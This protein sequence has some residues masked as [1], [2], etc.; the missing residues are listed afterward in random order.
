MERSRIKKY[1]KLLGVNVL[2][3][4]VWTIL[5]SPGFVGL[6]LGESAL[7]SA[8]CISVGVTS[9]LGWLLYNVYSLSGRNVRML[10]SHESSLAELR[11]QLTQL[12]YKESVAG[13]V[14]SAVEQIDEWCTAREGYLKQVRIKFGHTSLTAQKYLSVLDRVEGVLQRNLAVVYNKC[15]IFKEKEYQFLSSGEYLEDDV[16][17]NVQERKLSLYESGIKEVRNRLASNEKLLYQLDNLM[18]KIADIEDRDNDAAEEEIAK[19]TDELK[20]YEDIGGV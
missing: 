3:I 18:F 5:Y 7:K 20:Y 1:I 11:E 17:D 4:V 10:A 6:N 19:L 14:Q 12:P 9:V 8:L 2:F 16:D 15:V 13:S